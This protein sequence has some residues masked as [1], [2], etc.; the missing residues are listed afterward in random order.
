MKKL[1]ILLPALVVACFAFNR[2][3]KD[4]KT[5]DPGYNVIETG[6]NAT[7]IMEAPMDIYLQADR[8]IRFQRDSIIYKNIKQPTF[9]F[10]IGYISLTVA[11]A[12]TTSFPKTVTLDFGS[13]TSQTY[14]GKMI[15]KVNGNM[16]TAGSTSAITYSNL[17]TGQ[18]LITGNDSIIS[19]GNNGSG[20]IL[21]RYYMHGG[22][23]TGYQNKA[24]SYDGRLFHKY[25][26]STNTSHIDSLALVA[27]DASG[28]VYKLKNVLTFHPNLGPTC[29]YFNS[30]VIY[31]DVLINNVLTGNMIFDYGYVNQGSAAYVCDN[32]GAIYAYSY[33]NKSY[34]QF[35]NFFAKS[36]H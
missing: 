15:I 35:Y 31:T 26:I 18:S 28:V 1:L 25:D 14:T 27:T 8:A 7:Q 36:F 13:D 21:S 23:L 6:V 29:T 32:L 19:F 2:C 3:I 17:I 24:I 30:G 9:T 5:P 20:S 34:Q 22:H 10:K 16:R 4:A 33:I 11:P 12:D